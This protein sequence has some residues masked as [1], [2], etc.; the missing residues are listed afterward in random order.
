MPNGP[1]FARFSAAVP[2]AINPKVESSARSLCQPAKSGRS[3]WHGPQ[4]GFEK[5]SRTGFCAFKSPPKVVRPP[6]RAFNSNVGAGVPKGSP[7]CGAAAASGA[8]AFFM[9]TPCST[10]S[11][12]KSSRPCCR[13]ICIRNA[14]IPI[15]KMKLP[16]ERARVTEAAVARECVHPRMLR[17]FGSRPPQTTMPAIT[18]KPRLRASVLHPIGS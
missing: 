17:A 8:F 11:R 2:S 9:P 15:S 4:L 14:A 1:S 16:T 3:A 6:S 10:A 18:P 12:R 7:D 13:I 5:S